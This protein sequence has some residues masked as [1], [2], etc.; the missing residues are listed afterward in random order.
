MAFVGLKL[1]LKKFQ[2][3]PKFNKPCVKLMGF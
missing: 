2:I 1:Y 3:T